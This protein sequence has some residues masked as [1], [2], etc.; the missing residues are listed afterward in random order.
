M[1]RSDAACFNRYSFDMKLA[2]KGYSTGVLFLSPLAV[3]LS[4]LE[5]PVQ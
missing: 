1:L 5:H 4:F 3:I 2:D